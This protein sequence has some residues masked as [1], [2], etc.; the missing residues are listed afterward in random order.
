MAKNSKILWNQPKLAEIDWNFQNWSK[1]YRAVSFQCVGRNEISWKFR[2]RRNKFHN[3]ATRAWIYLGSGKDIP[4]PCLALWQPRHNIVGRVSI[5]TCFQSAWE[6]QTHR[7]AMQM[8]PLYFVCWISYQQV[9]F[10]YWMR[11]V[12]GFVQMFGSSQ[13]N[14]DITWGYITLYPNRPFLSF[15]KMLFY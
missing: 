11:F 6:F 12:T 1:L 8:F 13:I 15:V 5:S 14:L 3:F 7:F 2:L 4:R 10:I 9:K